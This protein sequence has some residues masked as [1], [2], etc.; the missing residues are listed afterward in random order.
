[1]KADVRVLESLDSTNAYLKDLARAGQAHEGLAIQALLQT[2]GRGRSDHGFFS[3]PGG[4]YISIALPLGPDC[5]LATGQAAVALRRAILGTTGIETR[6][7]WLN[8]LYY[9]S[10]KVAGILAEVAGPFIIIGCGVNLA[11]QDFPPEIRDKAGCL[12]GDMKS[13]PA[14]QLE[15]GQAIADSLLNLDRA[16][17]LEEYRKNCFIIGKDLM[18]SGQSSY[19]AKAVGILDDYR[20]IVERENGERQIISAGE[21]SVAL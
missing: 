4:V 17:C 19:R 6:I 13:C 8:D 16:C 3:P 1:M 18:V 9:R 20:L 7:K 21:V 2:K 15:L 14:S 11:G 12:F 10:R 5:L